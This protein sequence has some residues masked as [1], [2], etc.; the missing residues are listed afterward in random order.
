MTTKEL[1][2]KAKLLVKLLAVQEVAKPPKKDGV[3]TFHKYSYASAESVIY[4]ARQLF[5]K[6]G[7]VV[8]PTVIGRTALPCENG[9]LC[10]VEMSFRICD[11]ETGECLEYS[12]FGDGYDKTD[13]AV[14]KAI[15]G[16]TKYGYLM[17]LQI[18]TT[19][20]PEKYNSDGH[21]VSTPTTVENNKDTA[22][23]FQMIAQYEK[24]VYVHFKAI[25]NAREKYLSTQT[26]ADASKPK[27]KAYFNHLKEKDGENAKSE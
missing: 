15:T 6:Q 21:N 9:V 14:Y 2:N 8:L 17:A 18:P 5:H 3:N 19:D 11:S 16:C 22:K 7:L 12:C 24:R 26:L 25:E 4:D 23:G 10:A 20:D 27:L 13:K 1:T